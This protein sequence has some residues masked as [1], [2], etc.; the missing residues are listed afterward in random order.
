MLM[1][2]EQG[3]DNL[4]DHVLILAERQEDPQSGQDIERRFDVLAAEV[5]ADM[6]LV[7][8]ARA[9]ATGLILEA[10][11]WED[12]AGV[13][14]SA[15]GQLLTIVDARGARL[16]ATRP[17]RLLDVHVEQDFSASDDDPA[18]ASIGGPI[19]PAEGIGATII[20]DDD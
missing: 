12:L 11:E 14:A 9:A 10:S 20:S 7:D 16:G 17:A 4:R 15:V 18:A 19:Y 13:V 8:V 6:P 5:R 3:L 1:D 2:S